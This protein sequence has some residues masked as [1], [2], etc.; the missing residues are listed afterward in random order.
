[1]W[2]CAGNR[3]RDDLPWRSIRDAFSLRVGCAFET[4]AAKPRRQGEVG[5][6]C[7]A[8][9][10]HQDRICSSSAATHQGLPPGHSADRRKRPQALGRNEETG[11]SS[12]PPRWS[13]AQCLCP[14]A[15]ISENGEERYLAEYIVHEEE[16]MMRL[17]R[18]ISHLSLRPG[19]IQLLRHS[20]VP[21]FHRL[22][23][24]EVLHRAAH[25]R[26]TQSGRPRWFRLHAMGHCARRTPGPTLTTH[27]RHSTRYRQAGHTIWQTSRASV[28]ACPRRSDHSP[29]Q[30]G[31][32]R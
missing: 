28:A 4:E 22:C 23:E 18:W 3:H 10:L 19:P 30:T 7:L 25:T 13:T 21:G 29:R 27:V 17:S 14:P 11:Y 1:M 16:N 20:V 31:C 24:D 9:T 32:L 2:L 26:E 15:A 12:S 6:V 5:F 8:T